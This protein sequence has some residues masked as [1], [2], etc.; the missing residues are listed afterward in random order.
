MK[1]LLLAFTIPLQPLV[2]DSVLEPS[3]QNEVD[4]ALSRAPSNVVNAVS[5]SAEKERHKCYCGLKGDIFG[6]NSLSAT[7]IAIKIV[8]CQK[9]DGRWVIGTNDVTRIAVMILRSL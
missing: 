1:Q 3:I 8:S 5:L 4:H 9:P 7:Q 2:S 6:T